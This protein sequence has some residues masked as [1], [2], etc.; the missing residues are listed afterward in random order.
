[1]NEVKGERSRFGRSQKF[2]L[3]PKGTE[4]ATAYSTMIEGARA[5]SGR[6]QFDAAR[7]AWG[8][9][10]GLTAEDGLFLVEF[11]G[12]AKTIQDA[13]L[14]LESCGTTPK[15]VKSAV[16]RLVACGMLEPVPVVESPTPPPRSRW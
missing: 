6:A 15:E 11:G 4:A 1:M 7:D 16:T 10:R 2:Q 13:A 12:C 8:A 9:P 14:N 5:G 3:S